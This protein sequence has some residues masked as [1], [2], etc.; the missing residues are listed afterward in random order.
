MLRLVE[1][2]NCY[3]KLSAP[4]ETSKVGPPTYADVGALA[5]ALVKAAPERMLWASNWPHVSVTRENY[6]DDANLLD[7]LLEWAPDDAVIHKILVDNPARLYG[8][9]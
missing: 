4:Y 6:P 9:S 1:R 2:G 3:V 8:F 5:K 7:L